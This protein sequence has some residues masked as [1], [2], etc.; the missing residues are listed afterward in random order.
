MAFWPAGHS[1]RIAR[2]SVGHGGT[3]RQAR[4][5]VEDRIPKTRDFD[6]A[7]IELPGGLSANSCR[8][9]YDASGAIPILGIFMVI[10]GVAEG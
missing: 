3:F 9:K 6:A 5:R 10:G 8:C 7:A 2:G 4:L 1:P